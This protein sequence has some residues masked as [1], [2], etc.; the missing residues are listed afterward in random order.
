MTQ[1]IW[2]VPQPRKAE[3]QYIKVSDLHGANDVNDLNEENDVIDLNQQI[4]VVC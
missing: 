1:N 2:G 3:V 4:N